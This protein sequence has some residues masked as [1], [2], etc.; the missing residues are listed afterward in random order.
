MQ[1]VVLPIKDSNVLKEVQN[2]LLNNFK[3]SRRN[4]TILQVGKATLLGVSDVMCLKPTD[5]FNV[6]SN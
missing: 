3:A 6:E 4:D 5:I 1:Q 2:T